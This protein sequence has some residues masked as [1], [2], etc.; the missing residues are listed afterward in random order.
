MKGKSWGCERLPVRMFKSGSVVES[1]AICN[2]VVVIE[3]IS[4]GGGKGALYT[5]VDLRGTCW[6]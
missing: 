1:V 4:H 6:F 3:V 2:D 5:R